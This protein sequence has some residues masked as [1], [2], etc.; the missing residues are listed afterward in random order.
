MGCLGVHFSLSAEEVGRLRA[1][2]DESARVDYLY[3][4]IEPE[5]FANQPERKAECDK[6]WDSVTD[7][8][9]MT[10]GARPRTKLGALAGNTVHTEEE[11]GYIS[12]YL[13][14]KGVVP[15]SSEGR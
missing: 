12:V 5:Y 6:A 10:K 13:R 9:E 14:L 11:Y 1:L 3:E 15:P 8:T 7:P 2:G 4:V